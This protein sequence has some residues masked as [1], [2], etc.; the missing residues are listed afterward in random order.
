MQVSYYLP[1]RPCTPDRSPLVWYLLKFKKKLREAQNEWTHTRRALGE[2]LNGK[3]L[4][5]LP[6]KT[7]IP[8]WE[9]AN[10]WSY[11][12]DNNPMARTLHLQHILA[13]RPLRW[14]LGILAPALKSEQ[15]LPAF[16]PEEIAKRR[17]ELL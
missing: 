6:T 16:N 13:P 4:A 10:L 15:D 2:E 1:A 3:G 14:F 5:F 17:A 9:T 8:H 11:F 7:C 12:R